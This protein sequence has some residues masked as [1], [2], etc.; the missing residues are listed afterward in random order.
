[1]DSNFMQDFRSVEYIVEARDLSKQVDL[2]SD[3]LLIL[4][5]IN[6]RVI[7][8]E[9]I[10]IIGPSGSGKTT[11]LSILAGLDHPTT[12]SVILGGIDLFKLD[13]EER[14]KLRARNIGF[15]F[16]NFYLLEN[17]TAL[18]NVMLP[19]ELLGDDA[20][21]S[22]AMEML[23][24]VGLHDRVNHQPRQLSGGEQQRV[25]IARAFVTR[26][27]ILFA[28]EPTGNLDQATGGLI[29]DKLFALNKNFGTTL[30]IITHEAS[31]AKRCDHVVSL[32]R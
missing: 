32:S 30:V 23:E 28:D 15:V 8:G 17:L 6:L 29:I 22:K 11:L 31:L 10:A 3:T 9:S 14:T 20:A 12:G 26:P 25:A 27:A 21:K 2:K 4:N 5:K 19:L 24:M 13:E 1:M 7:R 16:Q 18:E